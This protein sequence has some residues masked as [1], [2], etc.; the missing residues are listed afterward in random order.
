MMP[1]L[2]FDLDHD[3]VNAATFDE[4]TRYLAGRGIA[5]RQDDATGD[6]EFLHGDLI[7]STVLTTDAGGTA[8]SA[9]SYTA[10]GQLVTSAGIGGELPAGFPRYAYAGGWGYESALLVLDGATGTESIVLQ[11]VGA[12]WYQP[13]TG[14][15]IMRDPIGIEGGLN[16]YLYG[17]NDPVA[18]V[19]PDGESWWPNTGR[20][21]Y[22][23][24]RVGWQKSG[25]GLYRLAFRAGVKLHV[26][27]LRGAAMFGGSCLGAAAFGATVGT[28]LNWATKKVTGRSISERVGRWVYEKTVGPSYPG[29]NPEGG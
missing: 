16:V 3:E 4:Q 17:N 13:D 18:G 11:H 29:Y 10:F 7:R 15:F 20:I 23:P 27:G 19:D 28:G 9:V 1:Y 8:V 12:R 26:Y 22:G 5:A 24:S 2:D 14:R 25:K 21:R 6:D